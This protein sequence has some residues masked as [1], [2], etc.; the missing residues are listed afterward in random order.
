MKE[1]R[2]GRIEEAMAKEQSEVVNVG[3]KIILGQ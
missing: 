1:E 3:K 2:E